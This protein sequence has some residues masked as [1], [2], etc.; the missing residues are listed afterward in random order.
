MVV[1]VCVGILDRPWVPC[2]LSSFQRDV[3]HVGHVSRWVNGLVYAMHVLRHMSCSIDMTP[4]YEAMN[5]STLWKLSMSSAPRE[6]LKAFLA[7]R[8]T[9]LGEICCDGEARAWIFNGGDFIGGVPQLLESVCAEV[10]DWIVEQGILEGHDKVHG[11]VHGG[12]G[13]CGC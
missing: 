10:G 2:S 8:Q 12:K 3:P 9:R 11:V 7:A 1:N 13:G 5:F 4:V 6:P